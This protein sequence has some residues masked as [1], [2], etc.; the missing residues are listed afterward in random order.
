[1]TPVPSDE[2]KTA[3]ARILAREYGY[4]HVWENDVGEEVYD[5]HYWDH[6]G[7]AALTAAYAIDVP[8]LRAEAAA[9]AR[10]RC[11]E[12][13]LAY[14]NL[15]LRVARAAA[16]ARAERDAA[17][18][19]R[20][21]MRKANVTPE[22]TDRPLGQS[23]EY[24]QDRALDYATAHDK[25]RVEIAQLRRQLGDKAAEARAATLRE[26][27]AKLDEMELHDN[28][29]HPRDE[30]YMHAWQEIADWL[31]HFNPEVSS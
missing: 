8:R 13:D 1:M 3:A 12:W 20:D 25:A 27:R 19:E 28:T 7:K 30:G 21:E 23:V 29:G 14:A 11:D 17:I 6:I 15:E 2:A 22:D 5:R 9:E 16:E 31:A 4:D 26:L 18:L 24:W 10:A